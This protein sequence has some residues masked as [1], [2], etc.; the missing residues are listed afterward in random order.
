MDR[1]KW[2]IEK[3]KKK[4]KRKMVKQMIEDYREHRIGISIL[5]NKGR[6]RGRGGV[7]GEGRK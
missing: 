4:N 5:G 2:E 1:R 7:R 6:R 3:E